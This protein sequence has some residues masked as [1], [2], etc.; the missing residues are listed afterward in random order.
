[1]IFGHTKHAV[2]ALLDDGQ[3]HAPVQQRL[4]SA[5]WVCFT[6]CDFALF[7]IAYG[8]GC[9]IQRPLCLRGGLFLRAPEHVAVVQVH[10]R[11]AAPCA[12]IED[13]P[14]CTA[15]RLFA[16]TAECKPPDVGLADMIEVDVRRFNAHIWR[17]WLA[18]KVQWEITRWKNFTQRQRSLISGVS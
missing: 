15:A 10:N 17:F 11:V 16:E 4:S 12:G 18:V 8:N 9:V 6:D 2:G 5:D 7:L 3:L 13:F 14:V 1:F